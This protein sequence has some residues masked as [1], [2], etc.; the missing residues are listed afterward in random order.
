[1][2]ESGEGSSNIKYEWKNVYMGTNPDTGR[3]YYERKKVPITDPK[4]PPEEPPM[5]TPERRG[6]GNYNADIVSKYLD[7]KADKDPED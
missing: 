4:V 5:D 6:V 3:K 7:D 2:S 1:M